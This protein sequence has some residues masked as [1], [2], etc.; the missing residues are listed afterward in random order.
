MLKKNWL[1]LPDI[2]YLVTYAVLLGVARRSLELP[3]GTNVN[4]LN[5]TDRFKNVSVIKNKNVGKHMLTNV[6]DIF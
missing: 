2:G 6:T 1:S 5:V 4:I 3:F